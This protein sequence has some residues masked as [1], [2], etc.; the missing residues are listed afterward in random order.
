[1]KRSYRYQLYCFKRP[2]MV[3]GEFFYRLYNQVR[4]D[5]T[6]TRFIL[7]SNAH[8]LSHPIKSV[9]RWTHRTF[10]FV[11][12]YYVYFKKIVVSAVSYCDY[13][14]ILFYVRH[15]VGYARKN[16]TTPSIVYKKKKIY[17]NIETLASWCI[18]AF[19]L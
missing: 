8:D 11:S 10:P 2:R 5:G 1:M 6:K 3:F 18:R 13:R 19:S 4:S 15:G 7:I 17:N 9:Y 12:G 14:I 16:L